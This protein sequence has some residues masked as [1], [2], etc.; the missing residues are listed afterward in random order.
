MTDVV[1]GGACEVEWTWF[2]AN[3]QVGEVMLVV[4]GAPLRIHSLDLKN[5]L[6][7]LQDRE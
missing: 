2:S 1:A 3:D 6:K 4:R 7:G 5:I